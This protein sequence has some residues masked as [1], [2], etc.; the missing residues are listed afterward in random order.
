[1]NF[2]VNIQTYLRKNGCFSVF[3]KQNANV[4]NINAIQTQ[5][6]SFAFIVHAP[7]TKIIYIKLIPRSQFWHAFGV[8]VIFGRISFE[9]VFNDFLCVVFVL[10]SV[11]QSISILINETYL[12]GKKKSSMCHLDVLCLSICVCKQWK[13][14]IQKRKLIKI[15]ALKSNTPSRLK[16]DK[17]KYR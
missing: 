5:I 7:A 2:N 13:I 17:A 6:I 4:P 11:S 3:L 8:C 12:A 15:N 1:M 16:D 14:P 9:C 10:L